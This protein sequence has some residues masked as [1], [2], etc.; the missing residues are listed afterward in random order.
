VFAIH[1][2]KKGAWQLHRGPV[3]AI[4][5][6]KKGEWQLSLL[7]IKGE[8]HSA[9]SHQQLYLHSTEG[10]YSSF[11]ESASTVYSQQKKVCLS[12]GPFPKQG[13]SSPSNPKQKGGVSANPIPSRLGVSSPPLL[14]TSCPEN[15]ITKPFPPPF[16]HPFP[17]HYFSFSFSLSS[18]FS[19]FY[20]LIFNPIYSPSSPSFF[21]FCSYNIQHCFICRPSD[22]TVPTDAG[23]EPTTVATCALAVRRSNH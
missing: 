10:T 4:H 12:S 8:C 7:D 6:R 11:M 9:Y 21:S 5:P 22:S 16:P 17:S 14:I 15:L 13:V 1:P 19:F 20:P 2:R 18:Y 3:F 23:I